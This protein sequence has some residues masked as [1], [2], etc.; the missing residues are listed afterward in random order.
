VKSEVK[1][2]ELR[3]LFRKEKRLRVKEP[4]SLQKDLINFFINKKIKKNL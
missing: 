4:S 3:S 2:K 1:A